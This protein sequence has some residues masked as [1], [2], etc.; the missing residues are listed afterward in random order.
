MG[1]ALPTHLKAAI[2]YLWTFNIYFIDTKIVSDNIG[3]SQGKSLK[4][5]SQDWGFRKLCGSNISWSFIKTV[6][7]KKNGVSLKE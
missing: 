6:R 2:L 7:A 3:S 4:Y 1:V 5:R